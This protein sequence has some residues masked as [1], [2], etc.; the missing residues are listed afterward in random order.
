MRDSISL[1]IRP[2][3]RL[4]TMLGD[5]LIKDES[6]ALIELIKNA[7][8]ADAEHVKISFRN[9]ENDCSANRESSIIIED[10]GNGM[11]ADIL[12][13][14]WM[15][16][17]T[18][19]KLKRKQ[20]KSSTDK[21]RIMQGEK[22]IGR[23]AIFK[24]GRK[25]DIITRRQKRDGEHFVDA[26]EEEK[27]YVL[28]YDFSAYDT[29]FLKEGNEEKEI[30]LED[31][32]VTLEERLPVE[33]VQTAILYHAGT[34]KRK[35]YGTKIVISNL[36]GTWNKGKIDKVYQN[37]LRIQ[38]IFGKEFKQDF[39]VYIE[40]NGVALFS[41]EQGLD[42]IRQILDQKAVFIVS[43]SFDDKKSVIKFNIESREGNKKQTFH[44]T[45][46]EMVGVAPMRSFLDSLQVRN[47]ECGSFSY[48][49]YIFDFS[50]TANSGDT[51]Y[52]LDED[53]KRIIKAHRVYLYRDGIRVMPYGDQEDDW[54]N[55]DVI[56]GT[57]RAKSILG[58]D[59]LVG[60][61][62]IT[63]KNNPN[64]KDKTN[65]EGLI[66]DGNAKDDL[67]NICQLILRY[68][69]AKDYTIYANEKKNKKRK[70]DEKLHK[71]I[72][73][74]SNARKEDIGKRVIDKVLENTD[75]I[76]LSDISPDNIEKGQK[77]VDKFLDDFEQAYR[78]QLDVMESRITI[79]E[80]LA[81][82][83]LSAET[84]Y[85]DARKVL[86]EANANLGAL[87]R[88]YIGQKEDFLKRET[89]IKDLRLIHKQTTLASS[90]MHDIQRLFPSTKTKKKQI[91]VQYVISKVKD[92]YAR[93]LQKAN[94]EYIMESSGKDIIMECTD[95]V[96][97]QVFIN[98]FDNA[99][100][101]LKTVRLSRK[102]AVMSNVE[103][104]TVI[105]ADSGPGVRPDD[106]PYIF[107]PFFSGKGEDGKG[108]GLYIA[109]QLLDR[110]NSKIELMQ[111]DNDKILSGA[112]FILT[113][114]NEVS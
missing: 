47:T 92:L 60:Y 65:R 52:Y 98:L 108:L 112:N 83:G 103:N 70:A 12:K 80:N 88:D 33:I 20:I 44:L 14:A 94:V 111:N 29:D 68:I 81:A 15:N 77:Y 9:F 67:V 61:V 102:I 106:A 26:P 7:Y 38:P 105:F 85:H 99:L 43:G 2:Y 69:R 50:I 74:I 3:A 28:H 37:I 42:I 4:I 58:N 93:S 10:D 75:S 11:N 79:T 59:Q 78:K 62:T 1:K 57:E 110:Y 32:S 18:P 107:E 49:F 64:L 17:A 109:R 41:Q 87:I 35:A 72:V 53:E 114:G 82:I 24:L 16:P 76:K 30:F 86:Q 8:D 56:R 27:E 55:L 100:F 21:G 113:F 34:E 6:I 19:E 46:P 90:Q 71:P 97:L 45:D 96:L 39:A 22:G 36:N 54:L 104:R 5:Q 89:V 66:E 13:T 31:L 63:Q 101:W 95:A 23:F 84:A 48:K 25:I 91:P 40:V 73:L 51:R